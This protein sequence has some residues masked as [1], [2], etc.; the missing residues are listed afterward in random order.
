MTTLV[1]YRVPALR[2]DRVSA[3]TQHDVLAWTRRLSLVAVGWGALAFGGVYPWAYWPLAL[4]CAVA[5]LLGLATKST[6]SRAVPPTLSI[7]VALFGGAVLLQLIPL[8]LPA[9]TRISPAAS[10]TLRAY[11]PIFAAGLE[12][13]HALSIQP[14]ATWTAL[15]LLVAFVLLLLGTVRALSTTGARRLVEGLTILGVVLALIGIVQKPLF[16]GRIYG[17]WIPQTTDGSAFGPFVNKNHFAGWML[18]GLPLTVGLLCAGIAK[19]LRR[20]KPG[21]RNQL[22]WLASPDANRLILI[23]AAAI[24]MAL[25]LVLTMSRS[26]MT[27]FVLSLVLVGWFVVRSLQSGWRKAAAIVYLMLMAAVVIGWT[28][29]DRIVTRFSTTA[30]EFKERQGAWEDALT[31]ASAFPV[32]GTG[33]GTYGVATLFYQQHNLTRHY[34]QAHNDYLQLLA[35]GGALLAIPAAFV[36]L[37]LVLAT[38]RRARETDAGSTSYWLRA[39]AI[40]AIVAIALQES[41]DFSLQMPGNAALFAMVCAIA[42]HRAPRSRKPSSTVRS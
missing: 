29:A 1:G 5:G 2:H 6:A 17:L 20:V 35:E 27:A 22:L 13:R 42:V 39:G 36:I 40:T 11:S 38:I 10:A 26:G 37:A 7:A 16:T 30:S 19:G 28:G 33:L 12:N 18:M 41:V 8:P 3:V 14:D 9:M 21:W 25:S 31:I 23:G 32:S 24:L 34:A 4:G 15:A